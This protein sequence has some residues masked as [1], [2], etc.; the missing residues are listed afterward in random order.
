M[1]RWVADIAAMVLFSTF[2]G[3]T[4]EVLIAGMTLVQSLQ[5]R[6]LAV[7]VNTVTGRPY[8]IYRDWL[9]ATLPLD[10][11]TMRGRLLGDSLAFVSFQMP[12]YILILAL[13]GATVVQIVTSV[14]SMTLFFTALGGP[15]G[16]VLDLFRQFLS[17]ACHAK[18]GA[19]YSPPAE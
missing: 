12:L 4:V 19:R 18:A 3:M 6:A 1:R 11:Q 8:G 15:Y 16:H 13:S 14:A 2:V 10:E 9:L 17:R 5:A 7:P